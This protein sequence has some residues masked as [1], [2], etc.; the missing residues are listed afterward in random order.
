[1]PLNEDS[2]EELLALFASYGAPNNP[3]VV[4]ASGAAQTIP[5][6]TVSEASII[7]LTAACTLTLP[8][9]AAGKRFKLVLVQDNTGTRLVTWPGSGIKW[10]GAAAPTLTTTANHTDVIEFYSAD[11]VTW[12]GKPSL[13]YN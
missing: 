9:V 5:D 1:M 6:P 13:N 11:G 2:P 4:A 8:T 10:Q 3:N 12:L 7:T